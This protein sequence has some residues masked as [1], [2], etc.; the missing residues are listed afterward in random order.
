MQE[1]LSNKDSN[2]LVGVNHYYFN[3]CRFFRPFVQKFYNRWVPNNLPRIA[4]FLKQD[5]T[6][7]D[8]GFTQPYLSFKKSYNYEEHYRRLRSIWDGRDVLIVCGIS[9]LD[10][11][12]YNI[13]ENSSSLQFMDAPKINAY[14][15]YDEILSQIS[16]HNKNTLIIL[17]LGPTA[18]VMT[19]DLY[20]KGYQ[21][22]DLGHIAKDYDWYK[23]K[24][25]CTRRSIGKF[26]AP[27]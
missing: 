26:F 16:Q 14:D 27:D 20:L 25:K 3:K 18:T 23:R 22:L 8:A 5:R 24:I 2:F 9:I 10:G 1:I 11:I 7:F 21:A 15:K 13:F 4:S 19:Y 12:K 17:I 6:Y